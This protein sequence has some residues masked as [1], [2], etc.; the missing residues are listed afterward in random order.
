MKTITLILACALTLSLAAKQNNNMVSNSDE[1][2]ISDVQIVGSWI[3]VYDAK[4]K[5]ASSMS[6]ANRKV[7]GIAS[8]FFVV[9]S[10]SWIYTYD[11]KCKRIASMSAS[12]LEVKGAAGN[13]FTVK[14]GSWIHTYDRKCKKIATRADR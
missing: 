1:T 10:G 6:A 12:N 4:G 9:V 7:V 13:S 11:I 8:D 2:I 3:Y 5:K 14:S